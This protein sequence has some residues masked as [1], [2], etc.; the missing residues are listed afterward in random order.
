MGERHLRVAV[1]GASF[2]LLSSV[3]MLAVAL[4]KRR[5]S[6]VR[7]L[8]VTK[9]CRDF[10]LAHTPLTGASISPQTLERLASGL[11]SKLFVVQCFELSAVTAI[12]LAC[13][14]EAAELQVSR[15]QSEEFSLHA[16]LSWRGERMFMENASSRVLFTWSIENSP[17]PC[18]VQA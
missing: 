6:L 16:W 13:L 1:E 14:G 15:A 5:C 12:W 17:I 18:D 7:T 10:A 11:A 3:P 8:R 4:M 9:C 2:L